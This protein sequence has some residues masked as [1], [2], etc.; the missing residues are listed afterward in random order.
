MIQF[1]VPATIVC[2]AAGGCIYSGGQGT[3]L[4]QAEPL[5]GLAPVTL[6]LQLVKPVPPPAGF[7]STYQKY[8]MDRQRQARLAE[9]DAQAKASASA[10]GK[11]TPENKTPALY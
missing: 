2:L 6:H 5:G 9:Q 4:D 1:A 11:K 7:S 8:L 3:A 10:S